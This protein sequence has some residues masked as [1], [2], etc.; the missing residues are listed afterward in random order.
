MQKGIATLEI[1]LAVIIIGILAKAAV[2]NAARII[3]A[4]SLDYETKRLYSEL[5]FVQAAG[6]S[7]KIFLTGFSRND[8]ET[9]EDVYLIIWPRENSYQVFRGTSEDKPLREKHYFANGVTIKFRENSTF[10]R[11][12][13]DSAGKW[14]IHSVNSSSSKKNTL[15]LRSRLG[16]EKYIRF[17]SV[18]RIRASLTDD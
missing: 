15:V 14:N 16:K 8:I 3:D 6:R 17:D 5:R 4:V 11:I 1:V 12:H 10:I 13:F 7:A 2:P 9:G 18:G